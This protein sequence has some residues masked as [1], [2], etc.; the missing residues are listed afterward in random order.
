[1]PSAL[2]ILQKPALFNLAQYQNQLQSWWNSGKVG[3][4]RPTPPSLILY[5]CNVTTGD[6]GA[7]FFEKLHR[8]TGVSIAA[9]ATPTGNAALNGNWRPI[10]AGAAFGGASSFEW[11]SQFVQ[12]AQVGANTTVQIDVQFDTDG[13]GVGTSST[14]LATLLNVTSTAIGSRNFVIA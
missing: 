14:T 1:M 4:D 7:E 9:S 8:L 6:A 3:C 13:S 11:F 12:L 2:H 5:G 10:F